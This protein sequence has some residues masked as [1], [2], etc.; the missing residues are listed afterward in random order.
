MHYRQQYVVYYRKS[1]SRMNKQQTYNNVLRLAMSYPPVGAPFYQ[2][3]SS[4]TWVAM[5]WEKKAC[6]VCVLFKI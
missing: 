2:E 4:Q 6:H 1:H 3:S 5:F